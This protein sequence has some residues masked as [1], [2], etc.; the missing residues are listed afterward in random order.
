MQQIKTGSSVKPKLSSAQ[1]TQRM[2]TKNDVEKIIKED[3]DL[4]M[5]LK[6]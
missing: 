6:F 2:K 3:L 1:A 4:I 5:F